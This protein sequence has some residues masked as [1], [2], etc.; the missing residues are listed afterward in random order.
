[1]RAP[2]GRGAL[3]TAS[4][5]LVLALLG[6]SLWQ[7]RHMLPLVLVGAV[8]I[9]GPLVPVAAFIQHEVRYLFVAWWGLCCMIVLL[10][11]HFS[12][13]GNTGRLL[14][15]GVFSVM[16]GAALAQG[17]R[18]KTTLLP[19]IHE[20][21]VQG[22][23]LWDTDEAPVL[24]AS[25]MLA[26]GLGYARGILWMKQRATSHPPG[27]SRVLVDEI[28][29]AEVDPSRTRVWAYSAQCQCVEEISGEV[30]RIVREWRARRMVRPLTV[31]LTYMENLISWRLG[32]YEKGAYSFVSEQWMGKL[33]LPASG[34]WRI[35][36]PSSLSFYIRYDSPEG[37][38]TYSSLL[39]FSPAQQ[40]SLNWQR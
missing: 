16:M 26:T 33:P 17:S 14:R 31:S 18:V 5:L 29:L 27:A 11:E 24:M 3:G 2:L 6:V 9:I 23:F 35:I 30:P 20:L 22:R 28:E 7:R 10:G 19:V 38:I 12:S 36:P 15:L 13:W 4:G 40:R 37:W 25:P 1:M 32:P 8:S 39:T 34:Q 21:E